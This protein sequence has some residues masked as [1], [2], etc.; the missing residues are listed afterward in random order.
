VPVA[1]VA[2]IFALLNMYRNMKKLEL[3]VAAR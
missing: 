3:E 2:V 1:I